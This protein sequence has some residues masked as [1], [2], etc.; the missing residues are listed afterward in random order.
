VFRVKRVWFSVKSPGFRVYGLGAMV[1]HS[2]IRVFDF[3]GFEGWDE[4][5]A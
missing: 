1:Y 4:H 5:H 2:T 3:V